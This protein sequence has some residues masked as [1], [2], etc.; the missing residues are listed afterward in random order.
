MIDYIKMIILAVVSAITAPLPTSSAAHFS[1]LS[2]ILNFGE[3]GE[4]LSFYYAV[5]SLVFAIVIFVCLKKIYANTVKAFFSKKTELSVNYRKIGKNIILTLL[6]TLILFVPVS[7]ERLLIDYFSLF[8]TESGLLLTGIASCVSALILTVSIWYTRQNYAKTKR[9]PRTR[10]ILR[11]SFYQLV[12]YVVPGLS[13]VSLGASNLLICDIDSKVLVRE[14]YVYLAP[15]MFVVSVVRIVKYVLSGAILNPVIIAIGAVCFG[16]VCFGIVKLVS[17][18]NI[19]RL[20]VFF[21]IYSAV[22]G[23]AGAILSFII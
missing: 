12:S 10:D 7:K 14:I 1:F 17:K 2:D 6:L 4:T 18:V 9:T 20:F 8:L 21:S 19:R 11:M 16:V 23:V 15:Q 5:F 22:L 13:H 3:D